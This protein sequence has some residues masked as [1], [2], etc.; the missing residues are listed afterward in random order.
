MKDVIILEKARDKGR[1]L[2][3]NIADT[4]LLMKVARASSFIDM[5]RIYNWG[6]SNADLDVGKKPGLT[7]IKKY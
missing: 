1:M 7:N 2:L 4:I 5:S 6:I 3:K